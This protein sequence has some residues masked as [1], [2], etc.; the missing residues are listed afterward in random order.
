MHFYFIFLIWSLCED[1]RNTGDGFGFEGLL[2]APYDENSDKF[3][4]RDWVDIG[5]YTGI[6]T[7]GGNMYHPGNMVSQDAAQL[8][9]TQY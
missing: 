5:G 4:L 9:G 6:G 1:I 8:R 3:L 7:R 2:S